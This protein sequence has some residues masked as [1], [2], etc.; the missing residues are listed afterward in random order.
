MQ[1]Q[2][3]NGIRIE[4]SQIEHSQA[5]QRQASLQR[6]SLTHALKWG[7]RLR[8]RAE[9]RKENKEKRSLFLI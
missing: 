9:R 7:L 8:L 1:N 2:N 5:K 4:S 6:E 3:K